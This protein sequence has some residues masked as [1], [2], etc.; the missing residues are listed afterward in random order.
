[1]SQN[2]L[3]NKTT[4]EAPKRKVKLLEFRSVLKRGAICIPKPDTVVIVSILKYKPKFEVKPKLKRRGHT[5]LTDSISVTK[6]HS[7]PTVFKD[8]EVSN[9]MEH[10]K[11]LIICDKKKK[12]IK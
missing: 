7:V 2:L 1:M 10:Q 3:K 8:I 12:G 4:L 5:Q 6:T 11:Y 9:V